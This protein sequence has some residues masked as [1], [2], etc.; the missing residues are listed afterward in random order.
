MHCTR[1]QGLMIRDHF[2]DYEGTSGHTWSSS[3]RCMNCG[4]V[5]DAVIERN[6]EARVNQALVV[7]SEPD[8]Q[9]EEVHLGRES[10]LAPAA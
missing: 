9:D 6:R 2:F 10:Y 7:S 8:Y 4:H 5:H 3:Q 1:C